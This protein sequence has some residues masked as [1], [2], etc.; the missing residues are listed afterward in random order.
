MEAL[1]S[2]ESL[3]VAGL[4][5]AAV[6]LALWS[7]Q[8]GLAGGPEAAK[9]GEFVWSFVAVAILASVSAA[10]HVGIGHGF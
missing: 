3:L 1:T 5:P 2:L 6:V 10:V 7:A 4:A 8:K 9:T